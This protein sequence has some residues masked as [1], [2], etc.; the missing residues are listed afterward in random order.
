[1]VRA[2]PR[3]DASPVQKVVNQGVDGDHGAADLV[4]EDH[5]LRSADQEGGQSHGEDLDQRRLVGR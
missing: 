4:P 3:Q 5:L 2:E 1:V